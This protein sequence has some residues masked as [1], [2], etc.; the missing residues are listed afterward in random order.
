MALPP[1]ATQKPGSA[2]QPVQEVRIVD[3]AGN[4]VGPET[5][6]EIVVRGPQVFAGYLDE[7]DANPA[8]FFADGWFRTGDLGYLDEDGFLFVMGRVNELINRGGEKIAPLEVDD[9]LRSHA[10][11]MD[12]ATFAVPDAR[13]GQ[14]IV[15][16][17]VL[18]LGMSAD[19]REL[20]SWM[21][22]RLSSHKVPRRIWM[23]ECLPRT[24]T[25]KVQRGVLTDRYLN[26]VHPR[27]AGA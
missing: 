11:V 10:A 7:P 9:V 15:A 19:S 27:R 21:L 16:A 12:A 20:R 2:G 23:V 1:P 6:G 8:A 22:D 5:V 13:L 26:E 4:S 25:G 24:P 18:E 14:D 3:A 17:V